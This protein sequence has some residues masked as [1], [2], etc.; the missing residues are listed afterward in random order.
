[1][2]R[3]SMA[4]PRCMAIPLAFITASSSIISSPASQAATC[5]LDLPRAKASFSALASKARSR[6]CRR[7]RAASSWSVPR[8]STMWFLSRLRRRV[9]SSGG[10]TLLAIRIEARS[11]LHSRPRRSRQAND[12][13]R[14]GRLSLAALLCFSRLA[15]LS[16]CS[17]SRFPKQPLGH[18]FL[19]ETKL[20][21]LRTIP[22]L[23]TQSRMNRRSHVSNLDEATKEAT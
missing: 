19:V 3:Y 16:W 8:S 5:S 7:I 20:F 11:R 14:L 12:V 21:R 6:R 9:A 10:V 22:K 1:M 4:I 2:R 18:A 13:R 17:K 15:C 23:V